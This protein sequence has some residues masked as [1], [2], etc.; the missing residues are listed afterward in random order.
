M[1]VIKNLPDLM[2]GLSHIKK[3]EQ[4]TSQIIEEAWSHKIEQQEA[5]VIHG[6]C[7]FPENAKDSFIS[8]K[9]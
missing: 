2:Y 7:V 5:Q 3:I 1:N 8:L 9:I 4:H 6:L